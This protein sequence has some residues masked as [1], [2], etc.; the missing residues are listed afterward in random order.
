MGRNVDRAHNHRLRP[1]LEWTAEY[2]SLAAIPDGI[3]ES[4]LLI[5]DAT[6]DVVPRARLNQGR[7]R[8]AVCQHVPLSAPTAQ[9]CRGLALTRFNKASAPAAR[10]MP[11]RP[12]CNQPEACA[13][14]VSA[15]GGSEQRSRSQHASSQ[16]G[17][18]DTE[19]AEGET[20]SRQVH[21][22]RGG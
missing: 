17:D 9:E 4:A 21:T 7:K 14:I 12:R 16:G 5:A 19:E 13:P 2:R 20:S 1:A 10:S 22:P 6:R 3:D 11:V 18:G 15:P 8:R